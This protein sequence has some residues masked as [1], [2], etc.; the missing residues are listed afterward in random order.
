LMMA[1]LKSL[2]DH[3]DRPAGLLSP[4]ESSS[5][6][7]VLHYYQFNIGDYASHTSRLSVIEDIT[8]RRLLDLYYLHE[9]PFNGCSTDVARDI[10]MIE[11]QK[12]VDYILGKFFPKDGDLWV[13]NRAD[14]EIK[15]YQGKKK[16]ASKAGKAS[17]EARKSKASERPFNDRSTTVQPNIK[18]KPLNINHKPVTSVV[19]PKATRLS[20]DW[21][22]TQEYYEAANKI[23]PGFTDQQIKLTADTFRDHWIAKN[24]KDAIKLDWLATW[25]N[26]VRN[27]RGQPNGQ[28][29]P[30]S[31]RESVAERSNRQTAEILADIEAREAHSGPVAANGGSVRQQVGEPARPPKDGERTLQ[32]Y[33]SVVGEKDSGS[34]G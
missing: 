11:Y 26:W 19:K 5:K 2:P 31:R 21:T 24:G 25:R 3:L 9:R 10:G 22:L 28:N 30:A 23:K 29:R 7:Y 1:F 15:T 34:E 8:Y 27:Q 16:S 33:I 12:E 14:R 13:N 6:G 18:H 32:R 4:G 20:P 17:A